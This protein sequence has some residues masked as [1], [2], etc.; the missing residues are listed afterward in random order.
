M[1]Y[2]SMPKTVQ[3]TNIGLPNTNIGIA[4]LVLV[5]INAF[6]SAQKESGMAV[7]VKNSSQAL[8]GEQLLPGTACILPLP[9]Y[10]DILG[11]VDN[12]KYLRELL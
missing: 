12:V 1:V 5:C 3:R 11:H 2:A 6:Q 9:R 8:Q 4:M 10:R 7:M